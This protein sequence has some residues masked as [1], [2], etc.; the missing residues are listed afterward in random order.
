MSFE[1]FQSKEFLSLDSGKR[2]DQRPFGHQRRLILRSQWSQVTTRVKEL[3]RRSLNQAKDLTSSSGQPSPAAVVTRRPI[4]LTPLPS[5]TPASLPS[6]PPSAEEERL[7]VDGCGFCC[8]ALPIDHRLSF[9]VLNVAF[10]SD[11]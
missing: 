2:V 9:S 5:S 8:Y 11:E 4:R 7:T 3:R 10:L 1:G 6:A